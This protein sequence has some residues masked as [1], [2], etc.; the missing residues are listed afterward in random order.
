MALDK[1]IVN[2]DTIYDATKPLKKGKYTIHDY[3]PQKR[4]LKISECI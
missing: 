4:S 2:E 3:K 1:N